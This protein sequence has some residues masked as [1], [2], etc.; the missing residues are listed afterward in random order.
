[1]GSRWTSQAPVSANQ[2]PDMLAQ[3]S[4][5]ENGVEAVDNAVDALQAGG[6]SG[7]QPIRFYEK[8]LAT[9]A[10]PAIGT[11]PQFV[12]LNN[13]VL[14]TVDLVSNDPSTTGTVDVHIYRL[15]STDA[16]NLVDSAKRIRSDVNFRLPVNATYSRRQGVGSLGLLN[17]PFSASQRVRIDIQTKGTAANIGVTPLFDIDPAVKPHPLIED[18]VGVLTA[19]GSTVTATLENAR[20]A[21]AGNLLVSLFVIDKGDI[22]TAPTHPAGWTFGSYLRTGDG[23]DGVAIAWAWKKAVG[24]ETGAAWTLPAGATTRRL[25]AS[26]HEFG[27]FTNVVLDQASTP[28]GSGI[29]AVLSQATGA[30]AATTN[31]NGLAIALVGADSGD[32]V[33]LS[34]WNNAFNVLRTEDNDVNGGTPALYAA[35][36]D[37]FA[38]GTAVQATATFTGIGDQ[39][40]GVVA[41]FKDA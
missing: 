37:N 24:G 9:L 11:D 2:Y 12:S 10:V 33:A 29:T 23:T 28:Q 1:M 18:G 16:K 32:Q 5:V 19:A 38:L 22:T 27:G 39:L 8:D 7:P 34:G 40:A 3:W 14:R 30:T 15:D 17:E 41:V 26:I 21:A 20:A 13:A 6:G 25:V 36:R 31:N 4:R 35:V